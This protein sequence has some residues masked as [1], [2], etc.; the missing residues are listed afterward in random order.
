M[1]RIAT[2]IIAIAATSPAAAQLADLDSLGR[3]TLKR[4]A[5]IMNDI[6]RIGDL[7][8]N[9]GAVADVAIFRAPD[10]GQTGTVPASRVI[11]AVRQH[12]IITLDTQGI[13]EVIVTRTSRAV[14]AKDIEARLL[15]ALAGQYGLSGAKDLAAAFDHEVR[16]LQVE[17]GAIGELEV[18]RLSF[19]QRSRRFDVKLALPGSVVAQRASLRFTG[20]IVE[21]VEAVIP[22]RAI[23]QSEVITSS[24][25]MIERRPK[26]EFAGSTVLAIE[27]VL[28]FAAKRPLR[29]GQAIRQADVMKPELVTRNETVTMIFEA[30]GILLSFRGKALESGAMGD[31][32]NVLNTQSKR[33]VQATVSGQNQVVVT[34]NMARLVS[35]DQP[36]PKRNR[37]E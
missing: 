8:E 6:V 35:N 9:A 28:E 7:V 4:E 26:S 18:M 15:Q 34:G 30:P 3:P 20:S 24:D 33:T 36:S 29:Q 22:L 27:D 12:Q 5:S 13:G 14:T 2:L 21:T 31:A 32:I 37:A 1:I 10:L 11:A 25:V 17:P 16:T 19:D 23:A